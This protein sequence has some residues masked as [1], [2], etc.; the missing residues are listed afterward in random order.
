MHN[1]EILTWNIRPELKRAT[2]AHYRARIREEVAHKHP[3]DIIREVTFDY[4]APDLTLDEV[5]A[6]VAYVDRYILKGKIR[7]TGLDVGGGP[8]TMS[9]LLA[10]KEEVEKVYSVEVSANLVTD[11][12]PV[13]SEYILGKEKK[14][15]VVGCIGEFDN[16]E[17]PD[18]SLDFVFDFFALHHSGDL[19]KT[20]TEIYRVLKPGGVL[21]CFDKV[22]DDSLSESDLEGL[23]DMEYP[24]SFKE[25]MGIDPTVKHT[26][27]MNGEYEYRLQD[28]KQ[29]LKGAG[30][31]RAEHFSVARTVSTFWFIRVVKY[32]LTMLPPRVQAGITRLLPI[33]STSN[34]SANNRVY[35]S[36]VNHFQKEISLIIG[37]K[38]S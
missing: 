8:G 23:L 9:S 5:S 2:D 26:R 38:K 1:M 21:V 31:S 11:L 19:E 16:I 30:F 24:A 33:T 32:F 22:R 20:L 12:M 25:K 36:L 15:A 6:F 34:I 37:Y 35:T 17:L 4:G 3:M 7:G 14:D 13:V 28:W 10:K 29:Y 18:N 27:G